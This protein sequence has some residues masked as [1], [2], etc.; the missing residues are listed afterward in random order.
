MVW[1]IVKESRCIII[2]EVKHLLKKFQT[3]I[4]LRKMHFLDIMFS[5]EFKSNAKRIFLEIQN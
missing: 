1:G 3:R 5:V 2:Y 4:L